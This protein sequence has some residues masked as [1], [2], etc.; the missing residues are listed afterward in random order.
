MDAQPESPLFFYCND[1]ATVEGPYAWEQAGELLEQGL[2][3]GE[4]AICFAE[5]EEW[6]ALSSYFPAEDSGVAKTLELAAAV[7]APSE[8]PRPSS[9][10]APFVSSLA[11]Q[12]KWLASSAG[13]VILAAAGYYSLRF[14]QPETGSEQRAPEA[15]TAGTKSG[16]ERW[17]WA[18]E[19]RYDEA[20]PFEPFGVA[21]VRLGRKWGLI[22]RT[23]RELLPC[24]YDEIE[25]FPK[26]ECVAVRKG[27]DS[28]LVDAQGKTLLEPAWE[29]V[30]PLVNGF[31]PVKK[32]GKWG[33]ADTSGK[34]VIPCTWDNAWRFSGAET[35]VVTEQKPEGSKRGYIDK[36]G[37]VITP[38]EWDGAQTMSAEGFGA[39]RRGGG[40]ALVG[41][42]GKVLGEPQW[43]MQW[44]LLR[45]DLGFLPVRKDG[46]W[47]LLALDGTVLVEPAWDRVSPGENGV[48]LSRADTKSIFVGAGGKTLFET[49]P[50]DEVRGVQWPDD[51]SEEP[52]FVGGF[53]R[54]RS[55]GKWSFINEKGELAARDGAGEGDANSWLLKDV[56]IKGIRFGYISRYGRDGYMRNFADKDGT[57]FMRDVPP[58]L[59]ALDDPFPYPGPPRYGLA[60]ATGEVLVEP[61]W[62]C[63][64][65]ISS[66]WVRVWVDGREGLVNAKGEQILRPEWDRVKV[67]PN[68]FLVAT[69]KRRKE[70]FDSAG[71]ALLSMAPDGAAYVDFYGEAFVVR[72]KN[73]DGSIFWSLCDPSAT[74][75][76]TFQ[77]ASRVYWN[78]DLA[79]NG[80]LWI[81]ERDGG[82]WSL[83]K[84]DGSTLGISQSTQPEKWFMPEGFGV[85]SKEDGTKI[86]L[87]A[88]GKTL[89]T[90][91]WED[92][93]PFH[94]GLARVKTGGKWGF[95]DTTGKMV[96]APEWEEASDLQNVGTEQTPVLL[97][98][99]VR[100]GRWGCIDASGRE[101]IEPQWDEMDLFVQLYDGRFIAPVLRGKLW[102]VVDAK[103]KIIIEPR[104]RSA[105]VVESSGLLRL[106][107]ET[108]GE[109]YARPVPF[110]ANGTELDGEAR[111]DL[112][113]KLRSLPDELAGGS[114][115]IR[116]P[117]QQ[118]GL[119]D[120]SGQI[121]LEPEWNHMA[122]V[123]PGVVAA[124]TDGGGG[125]FDAAGKPLFRD[126]AQMRLARF[127]H[128]DRAGQYRRGLI[129]IEATPVWGY[130]KL[131][132]MVESTEAEPA[133]TEAVAPVLI[134]AQDTA[135]MRSKV[136]T[137]VIVEGVVKGVG[138][139]PNDG[140]TFLNFG[141][142]KSGFVAVIFRSSYEK[143][144]EGFD[145]YSK[146]K[147]R[148]KGSL[149]NYRD[150]QVQIRISTPDQLEI[151]ASEP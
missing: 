122:W 31:I 121:V 107:V 124:W 11:P 65:V 71:K 117:E 140:I 73:P 100:E 130:A 60:A 146:Q 99:V 5:S 54:V 51:W 52:G 127:D 94:H 18:I 92:A 3:S 75:P 23:G 141:E 61:T 129:V 148:V 106:W 85:L 144:P 101:V 84:R 91:A 79:Q 136:G 48:L 30:Q 17:V 6:I 21:P 142:R 43:E 81:E 76:V 1:G 113:A 67:E 72:G 37:R 108:E 126:G 98:R 109:K 74:E 104:G 88:D 29:E 57:I 89:G 83:V 112:V 53:L 145:Q 70:V 97:A 27:A 41:K 151:L 125:T 133:A 86:H 4:T 132:P 8:V 139:G 143:F 35:A 147:V 19:P 12:R 63:A 47:G 58:S 128:E 95:I 45:A 2:V 13:L 64:Q 87:G 24:A 69:K 10:W 40:W 131:E 66:D 114:E 55:G 80:L 44:R 118:Y 102:G 46:K 137:E 36:S 62:D 90:T 110:D 123:G 149:E 56:A 25:V 50:W 111:N 33:Y 82:R 77:N 14:F 20:L 93:A 96:I 59:D 42:D 26:E 120:A 32:D 115:I 49:G 16:N 138:K 119:K 34:L 68:G 28:G 135:S 7:E 116:S 38:L 9:R 78:G 103:G 134:N 105:D 22:D 15:A 150:R 39:V